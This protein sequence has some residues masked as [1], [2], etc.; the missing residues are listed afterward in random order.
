MGSGGAA[1]YKGNTH[2]AKQKAKVLRPQ[3]AQLTDTQ[4]TSRAWGKKNENIKPSSWYL[5]TQNTAHLNAFYT[6]KLANSSV[7]LLKSSIFCFSN[8]GHLQTQESRDGIYMKIK[9]HFTCSI[10]VTFETLPS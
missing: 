8:F 4:I 2:S 1:W 3:T 6:E 7:S 10:R 5:K 9:E